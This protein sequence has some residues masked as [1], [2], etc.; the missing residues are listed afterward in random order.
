[1]ADAGGHRGVLVAEGEEIIDEIAWISPATE[2]RV[3]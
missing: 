1:M 2:R 3:R